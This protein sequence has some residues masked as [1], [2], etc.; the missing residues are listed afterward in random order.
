MNIWLTI[1]SIG[2]LITATVLYLTIRQVGLILGRLGPMGARSEADV[3]PRVGENL[4][5]VLIEPLMPK[6]GKPT[7]YVFGS[8]SCGVCAKV[9]PAVE[10][11]I[12]YWRDQSNIIMVYDGAAKRE[13]DAASAVPLIRSDSLREKI[14]VTFVPFAVVVD[15]VGVVLGKGLVNDISHLESLLELSSKS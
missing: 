1:N 6:N 15:P 9:K 7:L 12:K 2:L 5:S 4:S 14:G 10:S 3:G 8:D 11:L 13:T